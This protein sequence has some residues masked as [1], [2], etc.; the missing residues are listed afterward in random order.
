MSATS[1][2][3]AEAALA[4]VAEAEHHALAPAPSA[5]FRVAGRVARRDGPLDEALRPDTLSD[6][7]AREAAQLRGGDTVEAASRAALVVVGK[8]AA[9][10]TVKARAYLATDEALCALKVWGPSRGA[11]GR[12][13]QAARERIAEIPAYLAPPVLA[14]GALPSGGHFVLEPAVLGTAPA[15]AAQRD[16]AVDELL[17]TLARAYRAYGVTD[18]PLREVEDDDLEAG[19][20]AG[21]AALPEGCVPTA[22]EVRALVGEVARLVARDR[23]LPCALCHGD[24]VASNVI[25]DRDGQLHLV[26]WELAGDGPIA[27]DV[28]KLLVNTSDPVAVSARH[29]HALQ[30]FHGYGL[31]RYTWP[32]QLTL[33][34]ANRLSRVP[35]ARAT[36]ERAGRMPQFERQYQRYLRMLRELVLG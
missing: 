10:D 24:L 13:E 5:T 18:R 4:L 3:P 30:P 32:Q 9:A 20:A 12:R 14:A 35:R 15:N 28:G 6:P 26:D 1:P 21:F 7:L 17:P 19:A 16:A 22:S 29:Q 33:Y 36:A 23:L 2:A 25:R 27:F 8:L 34:L 31:R 11:V